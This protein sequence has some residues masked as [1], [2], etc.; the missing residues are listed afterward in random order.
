M[1]N[2]LQILIVFLNIHKNKILNALSGFVNKLEEDL[3]IFRKQFLKL[4]FYCVYCFLLNSS[5]SFLFIYLLLT[6]ICLT[7]HTQ[8]V[9]FLFYTEKNSQDYFFSFFLLNLFLLKYLFSSFF[10]FV[11]SYIYIW[12]YFNIISYLQRD[13]GTKPPSLIHPA[14]LMV[15]MLH[16]SLTYIS[17]ENCNSKYIKM[18]FIN[19]RV[20]AQNRKRKEIKAKI[21]KSN[22]V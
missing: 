16:V 12:Q 14:W 19:Q 6:Y 10:S 2:Y 22:T 1:G 17:C 20:W 8:S 15:I 4:T 9:S 21:I 13:L 18:Y 5:L 11:V 3:K 7:L